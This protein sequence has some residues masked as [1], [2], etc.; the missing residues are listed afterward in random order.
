MKFNRLKE[1]HPAARSKSA[2]FNAWVRRYTIRVALSQA[3]E[4]VVFAVL[5]L[6]VSV[7]I[8]YVMALGVL[9]D[10][11]PDSA[12][13]GIEG[14]FFAAVLL[15][16]A[17]FSFTGSSRNRHGIDLSGSPFRVVIFMFSEFLFSGPRLLF[18]AGEAAAKC[19]RLFRVK[20]QELAAI[21][22]WLF[23][24]NAKAHI[25]EI[26]KAF[27]HYNLIR[28]LPA[29][30]AL[31]IIIWL[32]KADDAVIILS[33]DFK[34]KIASAF[35]FAENFDYVRREED[36]ANRE[37]EKSSSDACQPQVADEA[38]AWY[39]TLRLPAYAPLKLVTKRYRQLA[40]MYHP[41]ARRA[42]SAASHAEAE[43][44]MRKIN[45]AYHNILRH[46][47]DDSASR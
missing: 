33:S 41:D 12:H 44:M 3:L 23:T 47:R 34:M 18:A 25:G 31:P 30:R 9:F 26:A 27:P 36:D 21:V 13:L 22:F 5:G 38:L 7:A 37:S 11:V 17:I 6:V 29:L 45:E 28:L 2:Q 39:S 20:R 8:L 16:T 24:K 14:I 35:G 10:L 43:E 1:G 19:L 32:P 4:S 40:K 15:L 42:S 46:S